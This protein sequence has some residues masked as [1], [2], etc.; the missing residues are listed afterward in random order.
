MQVLPSYLDILL[1]SP[2]SYIAS[3]S[4]SPNIAIY[5]HTLHNFFFTQMAANLI[6]SLLVK[7]LRVWSLSVHSEWASFFRAAYIVLINILSQTPT[8][9]HSTLLHYNPFPNIRDATVSSHDS[10]P[11]C[12]EAEKTYLKPQLI[13]HR[14]QDGTQ[15]SSNNLSGTMTS[16][17]WLRWPSF[18]AIAMSGPLGHDFIIITHTCSSFP[19]WTMSSG[20]K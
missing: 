10:T 2:N 14:H 18:A 12:T 19:H 5:H 15:V 11:S 1:D 16:L 8:N 6:L 7:H 4:P 3:P 13:R 9:A 17:D 20:L